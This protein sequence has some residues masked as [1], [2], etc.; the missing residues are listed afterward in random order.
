MDTVIA[1]IAADSRVVARQRLDWHLDGLRLYVGLVEPVEDVPDV[2]LL[3]R[4]LRREQ[5]E[6]LPEGRPVLCHN[7]ACADYAHF[8]IVRDVGPS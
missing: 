1:Q 3:T 5:P 2:D 8:H 7:A 6:P 4:R